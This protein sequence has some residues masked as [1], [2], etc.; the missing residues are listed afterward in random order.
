[1]GDSGGAILVGGDGQA[2]D[3]IFVFYTFVRLLVPAVELSDQRKVLRP[4]GP[5]YVADL[6]GLLIYVKPEFL[7]ALVEVLKRSLCVSQIL[8]KLLVL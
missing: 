7:I 8:L 2:P 4:W 5:L 1:V 6:L 3:S